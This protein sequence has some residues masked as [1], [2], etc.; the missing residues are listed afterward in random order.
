M[1]LERF[2]IMPSD[3]SPQ[4]V[5]SCAHIGEYAEAPIIHADRYAQ[6]LLSAS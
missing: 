2:I 6:S 4:E 3:L 1:R 5:R